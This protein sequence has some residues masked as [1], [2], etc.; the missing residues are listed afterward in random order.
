MFIRH[1]FAHLPMKGKE[2]KRIFMKNA[3]TKKHSLPL[4]FAL[5]AAGLLLTL[6]GLLDLFGVFDLGAY[7]GILAIIGTASFLLLT[8]SFILSRHESRTLRFFCKAVIAAAVLELTLFQ[9]PSY[10]MILGDYRQEI[11]FP[12]DSEVSGGTHIVN[13]TD[14]SVTISGQEQVH[15]DFKDI[16][17]TVGTIMADVN[18]SGKTKRVNL[19]LDV[20]DV[21]HSAELRNDTAANVIVKD[22]ENSE[23]MPVRFSG[24]VSRLRFKVSCFNNGDT[25]TIKAIHLN[26]PIPFDISAVRFGFLTFVV[27]LCYGI[28][29]SG[30]LKKPFRQTGKFTVRSILGLTVTAVV[31]ATS[32]I[33]IKLPDEGFASRWQL[34]SG[35]QITQEIVDAFENGQVSLL[36]EPSAGLLAMENPYDWSAR[37]AE[38]VNYAWDHVY[39]DGEYYSYYGV[40]PVLTFFLPYHKLTGNYFPTDMA[41]WIFSCIGLVFLGLTYIAITKRWLRSVPCGCIIGGFIVLLSACGIWYSVGRVNFYEIAVSSGF[42]YLTAGAYF[43]ITANILS[44]GKISLKRTALSSLLIGLA[45]LSRPTLA[46]YAICAA[47]FLVMSVK[48]SSD[49]TKGRI[50]YILSAVLPIG[51]LGA[52]QMWYNYA[53]FGSPF[54]FGIKYSLTINDFVNSQFHLIF[55]LMVVYNFIFAVPGFSTDY[56]YIKTPFGRLNA[57][58]YYFADA[59][60]TSGILFLALPVFGYLLSG[61][62]LRRL[63]D[64]KTRLRYAAMIGLPCV[65]MPLIIICSVWESGYAIRYTA[66]FSWEIVIGA[67]MVLFWL[68]RKSKN[69]TK[70]DMFRGFMGVSVMASLVIN[71]VQ[72]IP[73]AFY[74]NDYPEIC[75]AMQNIISVWN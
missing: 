36:Q 14:R 28:A 57:N 58:G 33:M 51:I 2:R 50:A 29:V 49:T 15:L 73:F 40:A 4:R 48:R 46:V 42:M 62:A 13:S 61:R 65:V 7:S 45:V 11:I 41:I 74:E 39:Y 19:F 12:A 27:T 66:D 56:P 70:K 16:N 9:L 20:S 34:H 71:I 44:K 17:M 47:V 22:S 59:G 68:Y 72:I 3:S 18:F 10:N 75:R 53:R 37:N 67:L 63:P 60:N 6:T 69:E 21:T 54:D 52:F 8:A 31:L 23:Y 43:L 1:F 5:I 24:E 38:G 25:A 55:M 64:R 26:S 35:D 32:I 30:F